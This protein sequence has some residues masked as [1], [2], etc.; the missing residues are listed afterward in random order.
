MKSRIVQDE[1]NPG[2]SRGPSESPE[3]RLNLAQRAARWGA[4]HR[5]LCAVFAALAVAAVGLLV[6]G[7]AA[8]DE[9]QT[10]ANKE[11]KS[12][13]QPELD[14]LTAAGVPGAVLVVD[15]P[16]AEPITVVSG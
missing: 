8:E 4:N 15:D 1:S 6:A 5:K 14:A 7:C 12:L 3:P 11:E 9:I 10:E 2:S 16:Q 13:L